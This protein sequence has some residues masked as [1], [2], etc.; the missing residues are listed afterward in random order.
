[1]CHLARRIRLIP[2]GIKPKKSTPRGAKHH[3]TEK[4]KDSIW[5][6]PGYYEDIEVTAP[7]RVE[8][9]L[10]EAI[11][12][13]PGSTLEEKLKFCSGCQCCPRHQK[14]RP[15]RLIPW[16]ETEASISFNKYNYCECD[17]RHLARFICRQVEYPQCEEI[18]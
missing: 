14:L 11:S 4:M 7:T 1:M 3:V 13:I 2:Q 10:H 12:K 5:A 9:V 16:I 6:S 15:K 8:R 17:C 18:M